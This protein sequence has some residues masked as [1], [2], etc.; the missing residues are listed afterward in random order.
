MEEKKIH[1]SYRIIRWLV[2]QLTPRYELI[3]AENLPEEPCIIVGNHCQAYGPI[4]SELYIPGKHATW[5]A[6]EMMHKEEVAAYS[7]KDFWSKKPKNVRW[8][9]KILSHM[10]V[11]LCVIVFNDA[12]TIAVYR[13][14]RLI[15]TFR[16]S[17]TMLQQG[18]SI[19]I[20]PECYD[21]HNNIVHRFQDRFID[22]ARFYHKKTHQELCFVPVYIAPYAKKMCF[23]MPVRFNAETPIDQERE[24]ISKTL[25][26]SVTDMAVSLPLHTVVP[27]PNISKKYY[28]KN[29]PLEV[30]HD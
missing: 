11:P 26:D 6:G 20:F 4:A 22:L 27:Y 3:G 17:I 21:E 29:I 30:Y 7:Y 19:V 25:M 23:G 5:C 28:P 24:R 10:I 8:L 15:S 14:A 9:Y 16:T 13:D 2:R 18:S 12:N 1:L